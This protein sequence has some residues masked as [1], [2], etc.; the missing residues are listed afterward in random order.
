[1]ITSSER[2]PLPEPISS[3]L[4]DLW[5]SIFQFARL[6]G[7]FW[8][9]Q[10]KWN[11]RRRTLALAVLTLMQITIPIFMAKWSAA[12]F[13]ALEQHSMPG[14]TRQIGV[15]VLIVAAN[16]IITYWHLTIK[17]GIVLEWREWLTR[18]TIGRWMNEGRHYQVTH[19]PGQHDNPDGRIAEDIR[20]STEYAID[21]CHSIL[22]NLL[23]LISF[24][25]MLWQLSGILTI[26]LGLFSIDLPGH[27]VFLA[28]AY[29]GG[30]SILGWR[31]GNPLTEATNERQTR[32][33][34]FRFALVRARESS[35]AI[36]LARGE[37]DER[38]RF[39]DSFGGIVRAWNDQ[40]T[41]LSRILMFTA[42]YSILSGTV[43]LLVSAPRYILGSITLGALAQTAVAFQQMVA[44]LSVPL[45]NVAKLAEW[46]ASAE[47]VQGLTRALS[48]LE[49]DLAHVDPETTVLVETSDRPVL[50]LRELCLA[51]PYGEVLLGCMDA[52][53]GAGERVL[54]AGDS[55]VAIRVFRA[56][57]GL[58]PWGRGRVELPADDRI[59]FVPPRP[60]LP[61]GPLREAIAYP[62]PPE[63]FG[64][65][66]IAAVLER[67]ELGDLA[68]D[69]GLSENWEKA[70]TREQQQRL[71]FARLLLH[72][73]HWILLQEALDSLD[74]E[75]EARMMQALVDEL[76][77]AAI[78]TITHEPAVE[79]FHTRRI[80]IERSASE[81]RIVKATVRRRESERRGREPV[82]LT[83]HVV[84]S[85]RKNR[86]KEPE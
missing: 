33:A 70:L 80:E 28:I 35:E 32:E 44:A 72:R 56:I 85:L 22:Y 50:A 34:N 66:A 29:A 14:L 68:E 21:L 55:T 58:W 40:T 64:D 2:P 31:I 30:A 27:L 75:G 25:G 9:S 45:D 71:G 18:Q 53:I 52:E 13:D 47:R 7:P 15:V 42:A 60:Y 41:V 24:T 5:G 57:A 86:R 65:T 43:P 26:N 38:R 67:V 63:D 83:R 73:P 12:L 77:D 16:M 54:F 8:N 36:S 84:G 79:A 46:R 69:L 19:M 82:G 78:L 20:I 76:P 17:R 62:S 23:L 81:H 3:P 4:S 61:S 6:A 39:G 11:I 59:F 74:P 37:T 49:E 1:M 48:E 51:E 10:Q